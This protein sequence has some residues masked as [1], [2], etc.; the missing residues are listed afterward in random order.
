M[1]A[2]SEA[3]GFGREGLRTGGASKGAISREPDPLR[4]NPIAWNP[5][6]VILTP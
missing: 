3:S 5:P 4:M 2:A 6:R 1:E